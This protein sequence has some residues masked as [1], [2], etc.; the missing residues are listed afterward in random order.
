RLIE[1][2]DGGPNVS[3]NGGKTWTDQDVATAQFYHVETTNHFPYRV[4]GAQQDNSGVCGP[5]R[6]PVGIDRGQW[7]DVSGESGYIQA[8]PDIPDITYGGDNS[9]FLGRVDHETKTLGPSGG[10][11]TLDQTTAEY[12]GTIFALAESP[13]VKGLIWAGS[14]DGLVHLTRNGGKTWTDVTPPQL[15]DFTRVSIIEASHYAPGTAYIAANRYQ[16]ED[17]APYIWK[18][19]DYGHTWTKI[20]NGI[21]ATE[22][23]RVVREDPV[24]RGLLFAGT[25]RGVWVSFDDG[26]S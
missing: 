9:G 17:M 14:D 15:G 25:E 6:W 7:Y 5:S 24:R 23:V 8:R 21:P 18:T 26:A 10:P 19:A 20:V 13:R 12:Y 22:F 11:I 2:N 3:F 1:W 16:L 4:C